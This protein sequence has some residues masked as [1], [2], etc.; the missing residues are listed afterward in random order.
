[1]APNLT[2]RSSSHGG[3][4][5]QRRPSKRVRGGPQRDPSLGGRGARGV[6][7]D[8]GEVRAGVR[9]PAGLDG[10]QHGPLWR[11]LRRESGRGVRGDGRGRHRQ[12]LGQREEGLRP[13]LQHVRRRSRVRALHPGRVEELREARLRQ[14]KVP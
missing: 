12:V 9:G 1:M 10:L 7:R 6:E 13:P 5:L 2:G 8:A 11:A 3:E 14:E 4:L